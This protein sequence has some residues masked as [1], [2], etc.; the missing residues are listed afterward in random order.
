MSDENPKGIVTNIPGSGEI[1][2]KGS[3]TKPTPSTPQD[4]V[5]PPPSAVPGTPPQ[6]P[7]ASK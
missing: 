2:I 4:S 7:Q 1:I 3:I 6:N 5:S